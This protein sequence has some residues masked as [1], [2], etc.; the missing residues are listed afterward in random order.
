[1]WS[2]GKKGWHFIISYEEFSDLIE[3]F[4]LDFCVTFCKSLMLDL[5]KHLKLRKVDTLIYSP[6][7][8]LKCPFS[9]DP[10]NGRVILPLSDYEF[11][12]FIKNQDKYFSQEY[13]HSLEKL[14][15]LGAY[16]DRASNKEG[17]KNM[18]SFLNERIK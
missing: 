10:R 2:S 7:R 13:C 14:G 8:Y 11:L 5:V 1:M 4:D 18:L 3:P 17:L 9:I 15:N 12:N 6:T 16:R